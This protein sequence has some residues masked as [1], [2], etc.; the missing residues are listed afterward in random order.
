MQIQ[1]Q[2]NIP[3]SP[4]QPGSQPPTQPSGQPTGI[5]IVL[6][7]PQNIADAGVMWR[8]G[9]GPW[10]RSGEVFPD[11]PI[12]IHTIEFQEVGGWSKPENQKVMIEGGQTITINGTYRNR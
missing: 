2:Q 10:K 9:N 1:I 6:I 12:G 5:I 3:Q 7:E 4:P 8:I 11:L